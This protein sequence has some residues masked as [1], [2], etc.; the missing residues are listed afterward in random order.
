[1]AGSFT[2][3]PRCQLTAAVVQT[4]TDFVIYLG[5][6]GKCKVAAQWVRRKSVT[7]C[8]A[9]GSDPEG[10][11]P[12]LHQQRSRGHSTLDTTRTLSWQ[13]QVIA[14]REAQAKKEKLAKVRAPDD[15]YVAVCTCL[16]V[17]SWCRAGFV[18]RRTRISR[19]APSR[20]R[21]HRRKHP[22]ST[23]SHTPRYLQMVQ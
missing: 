15:H 20:S 12:L 6:T 4:L 11:V 23:P 13:P 18:R 17:H 3:H 9:G 7:R 8:G 2:H 19:S 5:R 22:P 10:M 21:W 14:R 1:M 16:G